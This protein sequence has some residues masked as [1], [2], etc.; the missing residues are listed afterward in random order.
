M[1][2]VLSI[3]VFALGL[4]VAICSPAAHAQQQQTPSSDP[5][6]SPPPPPSA[7][8]PAKNCSG[9]AQWGS[10]GQPKASSTCPPAAQNG[11]TP[12]IQPAP[13]DTGSQSPKKS[14]AE[15]NPFPED[16]SKKAEDAVKAREADNAKPSPSSSAPTADESSSRDKLNNI[17]VLGDKDSRIS[18]G[19]GGVIY[20]PKLATDDLHVGQFYFNR[21]DY[22]GAYARFKEATQADPGNPDAVYYLAEAAR[23]MKRSQ[24]AAQNYQLYLDALP[25]GPKAKDARKALHDLSASAKH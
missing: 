6:A 5:Y 16:V 25:N 21:E 12:P 23:K 14:T 17:D 8:Q 18:D 7:P 13:Q 24:E 22:Q 20:N 2:R 4:A 1:R 11:D 3:P 9:Q 10:K 19:A 15:D